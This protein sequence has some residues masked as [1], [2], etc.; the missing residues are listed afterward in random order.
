M[1]WKIALAGIPSQRMASN[2]GSDYC[3]SSRWRALE[4]SETGIALPRPTNAPEL[5]PDIPADKVHVSGIKVVAAKVLDPLACAPIEF[6][7]QPSI[8]KPHVDRAVRHVQPVRSLSVER[9]IAYDDFAMFG[10]SVAGD[11]R[12]AFK[13]I[14]APGQM[15]D[16]LSACVPIPR[17]E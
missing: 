11:R 9:T 1:Y 3:L 10:E 13:R 7:K 12:A 15:I 14:I 8:W 17:E 5:D 2:A 6:H 16:H 4:P